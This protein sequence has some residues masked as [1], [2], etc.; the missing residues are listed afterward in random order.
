MAVTT[1][2]EILI[3]VMTLSKNIV[4]V[5]VNERIQF[6][7]DEYIEINLF[8]EKSIIKLGIII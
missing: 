2:L 1:E 5:L 8:I 4:E 3:G 6:K 7:L